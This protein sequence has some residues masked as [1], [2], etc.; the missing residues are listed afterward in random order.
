MAV[1]SW[2]ASDFKQM[3]RG[4]RIADVIYASRMAWSREYDDTKCGRELSA[5][6]SAVFDYR[7]RK[8]L[9]GSHIDIL[10]TTDIE[11]PHGY[12]G[13]G[14]FLDDDMF[15]LGYYHIFYKD[16]TDEKI[17]ILWG[18]N[19]GPAAKKGADKDYPFTEDGDP[20]DFDY[21]RETV[22]TCDFVDQGDGRY[23]RFVIP[24][25]KPVSYVKPEI[26]GKYED[27]V[28]IGSVTVKN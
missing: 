28:V 21:C 27:H 2:G 14:D 6:A 10:H 16:G 12:F 4:K 5:A 15:R 17:E 22:F 23:Y 18:E 24:T 9:E 3:Q 13:C 1:S 25:K 19:I 11:I 20:K 8:V 7:Y 26:F